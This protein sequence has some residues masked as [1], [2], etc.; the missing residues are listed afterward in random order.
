MRKYGTQCMNLN[1]LQKKT[2]STVCYS[3][4]LMGSASYFDRALL[5]QDC[6]LNNSKYQFIIVNIC[7]TY[8]QTLKVIAIKLHCQYVLQ[9]TDCQQAKVDRPKDL[10]CGFALCTTKYVVLV[11]STRLQTHYLQKVLEIINQVYILKDT[12]KLAIM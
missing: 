3:S 12:L 2:T 9:S 4:L 11:S 8:L 6:N 5:P 1:S 10:L 7:S